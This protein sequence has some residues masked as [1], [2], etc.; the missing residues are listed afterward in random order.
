VKTAEM[1]NI[2]ENLLALREGKG[3]TQQAL[4]TLAGLPWS[5]V[6]KIEQGVTKNPRLD[7]LRALAKALGVTL[8]RLA[9]SEE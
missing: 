6:A 5:V 7:T 8:D 4:A 2:S 3:L 9:G 1:S